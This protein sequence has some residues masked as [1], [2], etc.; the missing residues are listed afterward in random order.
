MS[1]PRNIYL[2]DVYA[3]YMDTSDSNS[4]SAVEREANLVAAF[5]YIHTLG[6]DNNAEETAY[7]EINEYT[8]ALMKI[9]DEVDEKYVKGWIGDS[10][11]DDLDSIEVNGE[12]IPLQTVL[13]DNGGVFSASHFVYVKEKKHLLLEYNVRAP[14][15]GRLKEYLLEKLKNHEEIPLDTLGFAVKLR[16]S[17]Y[18]DIVKMGKFSSIEVSVYADKLD[19]ISDLEQVQLN[20]YGNI[21]AQVRKTAPKVGMITL[22]LSGTSR[23]RKGSFFE[24]E[25]K[26]RHKIL[27]LWDDFSELFHTFR[28]KAHRDLTSEGSLVDFDLIQSNFKFNVVASQSENKAIDS[29]D[30]WSKMITKYEEKF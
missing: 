30:L 24:T 23:A 29:E 3:K 8:N 11:T 4:N 14:R 10:K 22:K 9:S 18:R 6:F 13:P 12:I 7:L 20:E 21:F 27:E 2:Y 19:T 5:Q 15:Q 1:I 25:S 26:G 16:N 17:K 28:G